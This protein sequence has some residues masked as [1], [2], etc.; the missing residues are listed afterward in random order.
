MSPLCNRDLERGPLEVA[1]WDKT[2]PKSLHNAYAELISPMF[3]SRQRSSLVAAISGQSLR[4]LRHDPDVRSPFRRVVE[5]AY[6]AYLRAWKEKDHA[7]LSRLLSDNYAA[8]NFKGIVSTK[9]N[10]IATAKEDREYETLTGDVMSVEVFS[11]S[12]LAS[13]LIEASW[14]DEHGK[15]QQITLRFLAL[16]QKQKGEWKL[17]A[18]QSTRFNGPNPQ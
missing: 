18:T 15:M 8:V 1:K 14:K 4:M 16:L 12:A 3:L 7:S 13:G 17:V 10:E 9:A 6:K 5:S 2:R 11:D